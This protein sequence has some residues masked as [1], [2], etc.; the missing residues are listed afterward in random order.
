[1]LRLGRSIQAA[2]SLDNR[3][4]SFIHVALAGV[5]RVLKTAPGD[6]ARDSARGGEHGA[7]L[8]EHFG[9]LPPLRDHPLDAADLPL[10]ALQ[11]VRQVL[12]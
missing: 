1:M 2:E 4:D 3:A 11:A 6:D 7:D 9:G 8:C 5:E 10:N 12:Q